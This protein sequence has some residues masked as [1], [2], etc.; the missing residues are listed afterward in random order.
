MKVLVAMNYLE[1]VNEDTLMPMVLSKKIS[2]IYVVH[3]R[4]VPKLPKLECFS[5]PKQLKKS[6]HPDRITIY[7]IIR[8]IGKLMLMIYVSLIKKPDAIIGCYIFPHAVYAFICGKIFKKAIIAYIDDSPRFWRL[9]RMFIPMLKRCDVIAVTGTKNRE[10]LIKQGINEHKIHILPDSIDMERF[11]P[12]FLPKKYDIIFVGR[13]AP[14]KRIDTLLKAVKKVKE[15]RSDLKVGIVGDGPLRNSLEDLTNQ[16]GIKENVEFIGFKNNTEFYY[17]SSRIFMLTSYY[18]GL[19]MAMVEAMACG[20]P[21]VVS[22][23]GDV[24]DVAIDGFNAIVIDNPYDADSFADAIIKL[25]KDDEFYKKLS[26]NTQIV[27]ERYC[28]DSATMFW[29]NLLI[30]ELS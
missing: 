24:T 23:V 29:D 17:N 16:L 22:S 19:P 30:N 20:I 15:I 28:Y 6:L 12:V 4:P 7:G 18:E 11:K 25:L 9:K 2:E 8:T 14:A 5:I 26:K 27:R 13:L 1:G 21:C 10:Y 3:D